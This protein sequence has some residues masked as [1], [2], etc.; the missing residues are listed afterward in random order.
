LSGAN[1]PHDQ[2][3]SEGDGDPKEDQDQQYVAFHQHIV[4][5][6]YAPLPDAAKSKKLMG[7]LTGS[8]GTEPAA[9]E[10]IL[11][12]KPAKT[13]LI[14]VQQLAGGVQPLG[15]VTADNAAEGIPAVLLQGHQ[16][17]VN[18]GDMIHLSK[19]LGAGLAV[20][21][22]PKKINRARCPLAVARA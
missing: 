7:I 6:S 9:W 18:M 1:R 22:E 13:R 5:A 12:R 14:G 11:V 20:T 16:V 2:P 15:D 4:A 10:R 8:M 3:D 19:S 21:N 17:L